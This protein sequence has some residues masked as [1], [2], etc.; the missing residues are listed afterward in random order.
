MF[1]WNK[2]GKIF[3][4][5]FSQKREVK[6]LLFYLFL[7]PSGS[8]FSSVPPPLHHITCLSRTCTSRP[9]SLMLPSRGHRPTE[10]YEFSWRSPSISTNYRKKIGQHCLWLTQLVCIKGKR[11]F[12]TVAT[13][14]NECDKEHH[15]RS[16][17][18]P[19]LWKTFESFTHINTV[20]TRTSIVMSR[21]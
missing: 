17:Q 5:H 6:S 20:F 3:S 10:K 13:D 11:S 7:S 4:H 18:L 16:S 15:A 1:Y 9:H 12:K 2:F 19:K 21:R 14:W 8:I